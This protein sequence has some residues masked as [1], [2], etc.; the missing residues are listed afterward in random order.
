MEWLCAASLAQI[1]GGYLVC[2]ETQD[3]NEFVFSLVDHA[4]YW[5]VWPETGVTNG[6]PI[7]GFQEY[8]NSRESTPA[9]GWRWLSGNSMDYT[10]WCKN[11]D[12]GVYNADPRNN[13]QPNNATDGNQDVMCYGEI[14]ARVSTWADFPVRFGDLRGGKKATFYAFVIEYENDITNNGNCM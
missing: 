13:D 10:N 4:D 11:L 3:E 8:D 1:S 7:G 14:S 6:P 2:P 9:E 12:D 5:Y